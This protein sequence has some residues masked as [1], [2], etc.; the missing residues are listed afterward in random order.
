[1]AAPFLAITVARSRDGGRTWRSSAVTGVT[2]LTFFSSV[3]GRFGNR[4]QADYAAANDVL[5]KLALW[6]D[7]SWK[8]RVVSMIWGPWSG[9]GMVSDL[10]SHLGRQGFGM[11][12]PLEGKSRLGDELVSGQKGDVEV[13]VAGE[14][15]SLVEAPTAERL[16]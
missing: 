14:L 8:G 3:A 7:R 2:A 5:N 16:S 12:P 13:I 11:I 10:E 1:M 15:G 9:V 4:G 6:L